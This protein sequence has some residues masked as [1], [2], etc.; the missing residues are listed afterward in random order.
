MNNLSREEQ[1]ALI[2]DKWKKMTITSDPM[3]GLVMQNKKI[4]L[5]L[6]N[7]ALPNIKAKQII[8]EELHKKRKEL[9]LEN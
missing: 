3:F 6:I 5:E 9:H 4:C 1:I 8:L 7:R 2:Y